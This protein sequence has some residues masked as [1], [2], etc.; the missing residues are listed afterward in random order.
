MRIRPNA[1]AISRFSLLAV[2]AALLLGGCGPVNRGLESV[3]QPVVERTDYALDAST[4]GLLTTDSIE[5]KRVGEWL[6][7]IG[8]GYGDTVSIDS[9]ASYDESG[10]KAVAG[11]VARYGMMLAPSAPIT[12]GRIEPGN[13]RIIVRRSEASVPNCPD[14][15]RPSQPE[16]AVSTSSN[17]GCATNSNLAAMIANPEDLVRGNENRRIDAQS[18]TKAIRTYRDSELTSKNG[19]KIETTKGGN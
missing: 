17:F 5:L 7:A 19:L 18:L 1:A 2:T 16:F 12:E 10:R 6:D 11:I 8:L 3:H 15:R 9:S 14:M 13:I 4:S